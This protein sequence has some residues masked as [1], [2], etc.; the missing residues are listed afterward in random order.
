MSLNLQIY[1][2]INA[3][4]ES[5]WRQIWRSCNGSV[6]NSWAW[7]NAWWF[8]I[9]RPANTVKP[10]VL[11]VYDEDAPIALLPLQIA[12]DN[13]TKLL[14]IQPLTSGIVLD[15]SVLPEYPDIL[16]Q[17][18]YS[19]KAFQLL[20]DQVARER[21]LGCDVFEVNYLAA[22]SNLANLL[23]LLSAQHF[24]FLRSVKLQS[25]SA[26]LT[27]GFSTYLDNLQSHRRADCRRLMRLSEKAGLNFEF[28]PVTPQALNN[29]FDLHQRSWNLRGEAGAFAQD[30]TRRFHD[31]L[32]ATREDDFA[33]MVGQLSDANGPVAIV[34]GFMLRDVFYFYQSGNEQSS[35]RGVRSNGIVAQLLT[36][37]ALAAMGVGRYDFLAG[38]ADYKRR[39]ASSVNSLKSLRL[40]RPTLG[41]AAH[42]L[43]R[44]GRSI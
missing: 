1:S 10:Y 20:A 6:F 43:R 22:D 35:E 15:C 36:M 9:G 17:Q 24:G 33:V 42:L 21:L 11:V 3:S 19:V 38:E 27:S 13:E 39:L 8:E 28:A 41:S 40:Y 2:S 29:L 26:D 37:E 25:Y 18:N 12:R 5:Q 32:I 7:C 16:L 14:S 30:R 34:Y 23:K 44:L 4:L 31:R